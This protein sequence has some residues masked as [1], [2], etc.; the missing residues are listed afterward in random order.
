MSERA[1]KYTA[2][3]YHCNVI[4]HIFASLSYCLDCKVSVA[5]ETIEVYGKKNFISWGYLQA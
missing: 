5:A 4:P 3:K 2:G 1:A